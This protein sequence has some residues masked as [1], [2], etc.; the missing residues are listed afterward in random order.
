M[1]QFTLVSQQTRVLTSFSRF[2]YSKSFGFR[3]YRPPADSRV[4]N[5]L[6]RSRRLI[7]TR[8]ARE[9]ARARTDDREREGDTRA[10]PFLAGVFVVRSRA[11]RETSPRAPPA[12]ARARWSRECGEWSAQYGDKTIGR[13]GTLCVTTHSARY[14]TYVGLRQW[15]TESSVTRGGRRPDRGLG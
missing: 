8:V 12:P 2:L 7:S 5:P 14:L 9:A 11:R 1:C 3:E 6:H 4:T 10:P 15:A 13:R